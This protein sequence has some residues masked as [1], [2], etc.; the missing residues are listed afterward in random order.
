MKRRILQLNEY[1]QKNGF[2][3]DV[4]MC[5]APRINPV[6]S[7]SRGINYWGSYKKI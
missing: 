7:T 4:M 1:V 6:I 5:D 2:I 3:A